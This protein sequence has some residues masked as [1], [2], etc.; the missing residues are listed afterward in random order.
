MSKSKAGNSTGKVILYKKE[1]LAERLDDLRHDK[2]I[3]LETL[4]NKSINF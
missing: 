3:S 4:S 2:G 1:K